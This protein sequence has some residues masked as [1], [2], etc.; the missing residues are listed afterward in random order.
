[1]HG[2]IIAWFTEF[3]VLIHTVALS[4]MVPSFF[5]NFL[6][7]IILTRWQEQPVGFGATVVRFLMIVYNLHLNLIDYFL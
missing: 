5:P 6:L 7:W 4:N 2:W 3:N 1:M